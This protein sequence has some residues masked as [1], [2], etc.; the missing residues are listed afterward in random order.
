MA[1]HEIPDAVEYTIRY[2]YLIWDG[3]DATA[4]FLETAHYRARTTLGDA[5]AGWSI[6]QRTPTKRSRENAIV[7]VT[8]RLNDPDTQRI[9][10]VKTQLATIFAE[11]PNLPQLEL[12]APSQKR[13]DFKAE[14]GAFI[15]DA[16]GEQNVTEDPV[17]EAP[18]A[19]RAAGD[20]NTSEDTSRGAEDAG[21]D[22]ASDSL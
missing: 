10:E 19:R 2:K 6:A 4:T 22:S 17:I 8:V 9:E 3:S 13:G 5:F 20:H 21:G 14:V 15:R 16:V 18:L 12:W 1:R 7:T 11:A